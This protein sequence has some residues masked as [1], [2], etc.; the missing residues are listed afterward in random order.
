MA[1]QHITSRQNARVKE[2]AK[3]RDARQRQKQ[4]RFVIDGGRE[5]LRAVDCG[6]EV[7][8]AFLCESLVRDAESQAAAARLRIPLRAGLRSLNVAITAA[9][10]LGEALRQ[11]EGFPP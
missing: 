3:L 8:E 6:V 10:V 11:T 9:M 4:E 7:V 5:I 2:A 1:V